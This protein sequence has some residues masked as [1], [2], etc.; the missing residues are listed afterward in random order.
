MLA[1]VVNCRERKRY[2]IKCLIRYRTLRYQ[3]CTVIQKLG[4]SVCVWHKHALGLT[5][6]A[7]GVL[8]V[9]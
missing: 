4:W 1:C 5:T 3:F 8:V 2:K 9:D 6:A 7:I